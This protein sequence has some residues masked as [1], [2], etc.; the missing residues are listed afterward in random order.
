MSFTLV[1]E[2]HATFS[3]FD[4]E[5]K[6]VKVLKEGMFEAGEQSFIWESGS[7]P[8]GAYLLQLTADG[9]T[10]TEKIIISR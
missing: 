8:Q 6:L 1:K 2:S 3:L 9:Q 4:M 5:G 10:Q 7:M